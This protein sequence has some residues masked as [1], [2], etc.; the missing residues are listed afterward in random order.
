M[1][2]FRCESRVQDPRGGRK[3]AVT[4]LR[5]IPMAFQTQW[6]GASNPPDIEAFLSRH[7]V[8]DSVD[9]LGV[10]LIDQ[11][12]RWKTGCVLPIKEY[13]SRF[14]EVARRTELRDEL[15]LEEFGYREERFGP[16]DVDT[17]LSS[18]AELPPQ[19]L[20]HLRAQL[21][22]EST[23]DS[24][25]ANGQPGAADAETQAISVPPAPAALEGSAS[26]SRLLGM[27]REF[28]DYEVLELIA[29]GGMGV[30]YKAR[31]KSLNRI[32]ALKMILSGQHASRED[33][34]RFQREAQ[35]AAALEHPGIVPVFE[36]GVRAGH[37][38]LT[39]G[40]VA[41]DSLATRL[42]QGPLDPK[43]AATIIAQ[44]ADAV[45]C[46]H[47]HGIIHRDLKPANVLLDQGE[48]PRVSDFGLAKTV[49]TDRDLTESGQVLGTPS[50]MPP[51]QAAGNSSAVGMASD[52][53]SI[54]ALFYAC[55]TGRP[56]FQAASIVDT[57]NQVL[58]DPPISP[59]Q[60]NSRVPSEAATICLK[61]LE[62]SPPDRYAS[63][64]DVRNELQRFLA[65]V[66][67]Q[68]RPLGPTA[69]I[70]RW[71]RRHPMPTGLIAALFVA[72]IAITIA[73]ET[74]RT[75]RTTQ[76]VGALRTAIERRLADPQLAEAYVDDLNDSIEALAAHEPV[77][78][79]GYQ[80]RL[81]AAYATLISQQLANSDLTDGKAAQLREAIAVLAKRDRPQANVLSAALYEQ[82]DKWTVALEL[83]PTRDETLLS[84]QLKRNGNPLFGSTTAIRRVIAN[85]PWIR[86]GGTSATTLEL[87]ATFSGKW[88]EQ[89]YLGIGFLTPPA[90]RPGAPSP[91]PPIQPNT[92]PKNLEFRRDWIRGYQLVC[93]PIPGARPPLQS[94]GDSLNALGEVRL[95]LSH[96]DNLLAAVSVSAAQLEPPPTQ[97][98]R[99]RPVEPTRLQLFLRRDQQRWLIELNDAPV[100]TFHE[101]FPQY[102][103]RID[104][105]ILWPE[106]CDAEDI[107]ARHNLS[108]SPP[109]QLVQADQLARQGRFRKAVVRYRSCR[110]QQEFQGLAVELALKTAICQVSLGQLDDG[111]D[112][113]RRV[114]DAGS[115]PHSQRAACELLAAF[116]N[117]EQH[118]EADLVFAGILGNMQPEAMARQIPSRL[119][120]Q[121]VA[122]YTAPNGRPNFP[123]TL[124]TVSTLEKITNIQKQIAAPL[125]EQLAARR[126][127]LQ[128]RRF[129]GEWDE[130]ISET[131]RW[132]AASYCSEF[133]RFTLV[134]WLVDS[135]LQQGASGSEQR[136]LAAI[137]QNRRR[138]TS[139]RGSSL[140]LTHRAR[141]HAHMGR[142][143]LSQ[144]DIDYVFQNVPEP[145]ILPPLPWIISGLLA[146]RH[147][148]DPKLAEKI[149]RR[150][151]ATAKASDGQWRLILSALGGV[152]SP[153]DLRSHVNDLA[154]C[155]E[156]GRL[157]AMLAPLATTVLPTSVLK[158]ALCDSW[159]SPIGRAQLK[160]IVF[161]E[162]SSARLHSLVAQVSTYGLLKHILIQQE[163]FSSLDDTQRAGLWR[164]STDLYRAYVDGEI[165]PSDALFAIGTLQEDLA[166]AGWTMIEQHWP[167]RVAAPLAYLAANHLNRRGDAHEA[168]R[169]LEFAV[170]Q[171]SHDHPL[172][173]KI[174]QSR[175]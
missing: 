124:R 44:V 33:I 28:G 91:H 3:Q 109:D 153:G 92:E 93:R 115:A 36:V 79:S 136:A 126:Q 172:Y 148:Q 41:G 147:R 61:C 137:E 117:Q 142:F 102:D 23:S 32:V 114:M 157:G 68:A 21:K 94:L 167:R 123:P 20:A 87:T 169:L 49:E 106:G 66:P 30:V 118:R 99:N 141:L 70:Y 77:P 6:E 132:L 15:I 25:F 59:R 86:L 104:F 11:H 144:N 34:E 31:Q 84:P 88:R 80:E 50:Y 159:N 125:D 40:Y 67:I 100:L 82:I 76:V 62:K 69:R 37:H 51:E 108:R 151:A 146:E 89:P 133:D 160:R 101:L 122:Y 143:D 121:I 127:L 113:L 111:L 97:R 155:S 26:G 19:E 149:W 173:E 47:A 85:S 39:M 57:L 63:A 103:E 90:E 156:A 14:P 56:P 43:H 138:E 166:P 134:G 163:P 24:F 112:G 55:L 27:E 139:Q 129:L 35:A 10:L 64:A 96:G 18:F 48:R 9:I 1:V 54:G 116:I 45:A 110:G 74:S 165:S 4:R 119:L 81:T 98:T 17:F 105:G 75:T 2:E 174:L 29:R 130:V 171:I 60:I 22:P 46:A 12:F 140:L 131:S 13:L 135:Y 16:T 161:F 73:V 107:L 162:E 175:P 152:H 154:A 42:R 168:R 65:G 95:E 38:Y 58:S 158:S 145:E 150:G 164:L 83:T 71:C 170:S 7:G 5:P 128:A 120:S 78:A 52:V 72:I 8:R 53:Y